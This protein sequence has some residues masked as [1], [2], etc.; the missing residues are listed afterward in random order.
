MFN[1][2]NYNIS[3]ID[4]TL[5][6]QLQTKIDNL[7]KP[8]GSLGKLE[9]VAIVLGSI[10]GSL[11]PVVQKPTVVTFA[12]DHGVVVEGVSPCP[13]EITWQQVLNFCQGGGGI[14]V[15]CQQFDIEHVVVDAGVDYDFN[16]LEGLVDLKVR[17]STRN[18]LYEPAMTDEECNQAMLNS[19]NLI[20]KLHS[21]G[22]NTIGFGEMGIGNTSPASIIMSKLLNLNLET[23][24]GPGA[25]HNAEGVFKKYETLK[26]S[27]E[28]FPEVSSAYDV[29]K[30]FG[31]LEIAMMVAGILKSAELKMTVLIDGFICTA[32][33]VVASQLNPLV[34]DYCIFSHQSDEGGH[35]L[36]L[37]TLNVKALLHLDFR[38]GEGTGSAMA[39]PV[40]QA[41]CRMINHMKSFDASN[42]T[43]TTH[44]LPDEY[45]KK[46]M[47]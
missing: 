2:I 31:G 19:S 13:K 42:V 24:V 40:L 7:A 28:K 3:P 44:I 12:A 34:K 47:E 10:Q 1:M 32:A 45:A 39:V 18:F 41:A 29:L 16:N 25:G 26:S 33:Y 35:K 20:E 23:C 6:K 21:K 15:L 46:R 22:C 43:N 37:D 27:V 14:S 17:K 38:L 11:S 5:Y 4:R 36:M 30:T 9:D 8:V